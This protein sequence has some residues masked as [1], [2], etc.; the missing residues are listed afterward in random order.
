M[1]H[2]LILDDL[3]KSTHKQQEIEKHESSKARI[4]IDQINNRWERKGGVRET[5]GEDP[6][7]ECEY[8]N[9]HEDKEAEDTTEGAPEGY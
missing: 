6:D 4:T 3:D 5:Y 9:E 8:P 1:N 7:R 2:A